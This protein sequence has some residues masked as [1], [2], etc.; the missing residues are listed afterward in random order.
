MVETRQDAVFFGAVASAQPPLGA[1]SILPCAMA[2]IMLHV[3]IP[4]RSA[5]IMLE[6][7]MLC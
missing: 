4:A 5:S 2:L 6:N 1:L 3:L 7:S